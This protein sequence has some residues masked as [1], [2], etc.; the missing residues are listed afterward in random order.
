VKFN[1]ALEATDKTGNMLVT[2]KSGAEY[3]VSRDMVTYYDD[4][5]YI[6]GSRTNAAPR[7]R[8][9]RGRGA[10]NGDIRWFYLKNLTLVTP[11]I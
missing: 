7:N 9:R 4:G 10:E 8:F 6:Y 5:A 1:A 3:I 11:N 2:T